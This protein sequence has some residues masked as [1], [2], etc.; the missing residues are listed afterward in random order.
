M[1]SKKKYRDI[2]TER[3]RKILEAV[4]RDYI[5]NAYPVSSRQVHSKYMQDIS[6]ATIRNTMYLLEQKGYISQPHISAGRVPTDKGYRYYVNTLIER[7][8]VENSI[9]EMVERELFETT[10]D[11][12]LLVEKAV[13]LLSKLTNELSV[14][15][16]PMYTSGILEKIDLI[17]ISENRILMVLEVKSGLMKTAILSID[18][19]IA[20][21]KLALITSVLNERLAG[22]RLGEIIDTIHERMSDIIDDVVIKVIIENAPAVF[23]MSCI[24]KV[25][26]SGTTNLFRKP[27][28]KDTR[29]L[30]QIVSTIENGTIVANIYKNRKARSGIVITI[31]KENK[32]EAM[33]DISVVMKDYLAGDEKGFIG[34]VGP[35]RMDYAK[36][37]KMVRCFADVISHVFS[38]R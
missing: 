11:L 7:C 35:K 13:K 34:V 9:Y 27:D 14:F 4:V 33:K 15:I 32:R 6:P 16:A 2:L 31:G 1:V 28:F 20:P 8:E 17:S 23:D 22:I 24:D 26:M 21:R 5:D 19:E 10:L 12:T 36:A 37:I 38:S 18:T 30:G 3:E 25:K 29:L